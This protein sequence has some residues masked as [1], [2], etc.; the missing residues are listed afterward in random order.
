MT[1]MTQQ[2]PIRYELI[3]TCAQTGARLGIVHRHTVHL[4]R[5]HLC[6]LEHRLL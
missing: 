3:K 5:Q 4:K 6:Q 2:P 1:E